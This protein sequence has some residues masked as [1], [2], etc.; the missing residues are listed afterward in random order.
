MAGER[1]S[2][3]ARWA[4]KVGSVTTPACG[5]TAAA[6]VEDRKAEVPRWTSIYNTKR[7]DLAD[8]SLFRRFTISP[9]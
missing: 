3:D 8:S 6:F 2:D 1:Y 4:R 9:E 7:V 5:A